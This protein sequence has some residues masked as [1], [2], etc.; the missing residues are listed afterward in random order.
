[1]PEP[2]SPRTEPDLPPS[3]GVSCA[4][5]GVIDPHVVGQVGQLIAFAL[6][7]GVALHAVERLVVQAHL[8]V[9]IAHEHL[10]N[11]A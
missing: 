5:D 7:V 9:A 2:V 6:A 11:G 8:V 10:G 3:D 1:M 4:E